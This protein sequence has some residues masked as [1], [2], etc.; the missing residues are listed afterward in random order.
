MKIVAKVNEKN[1]IVSLQIISL[2]FVRQLIELMK[3]I[4]PAYWVTNPEYKETEYY[5]EHVIRSYD[6]EIEEAARRMM[7]NREQKTLEYCFKEGCKL[8]K[9]YD[10]DSRLPKWEISG[11]GYKTLLDDKHWIQCDV[12]PTYQRLL[13]A[14]HKI[15]FSY[16]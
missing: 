14:G 12:Q 8:W 3:I 2:L 1:E 15:E 10:L 7:N 11:Y 16:F 4:N 13:D 9:Y 5:G 6:R